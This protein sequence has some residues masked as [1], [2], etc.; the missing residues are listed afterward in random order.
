MEED[1]KKLYFMFTD[2]CEPSL[3]IKLNGTEGY[4]NSHNV[5]DEIKLLDFIRSF[6]CG[7]E[8]NLQGTWAIFK[9]NKHLYTLLHRTNVTNNDCTK[10]SNA[11][12]KVIDP[13]R[14]QTPIHHGPFK[15]TITKMG[16]HDTNDPTLK[17]KRRSQKKNWRRNT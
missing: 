17:Q 3:K 8:A 7:A 15:S 16:V 13:Y 14:V 4:N 11:Y 5:K 9:A 10:E 12:I 2:Q 1:N 6:V